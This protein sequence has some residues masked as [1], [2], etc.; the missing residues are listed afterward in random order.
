MKKLQK[1]QFYLKYIV[2]KF[3]YLLQYF[4]LNYFY[5]NKVKYYIVNFHRTILNTTTLR[6]GKTCATE[7]IFYF[8]QNVIAL[9]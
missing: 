1:I 8:G 9:K 5:L 4:Y 6:S 7:L 2:L 3:M